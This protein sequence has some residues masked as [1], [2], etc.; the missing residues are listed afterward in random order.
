MRQVCVSYPSRRSS[1]SSLGEPEIQHLHDAVGRDDDV[2]RLQIAMHD[3]A[4]M[5]GI[6]RLA[7]LTRDRQ[8]L[9]HRQPSAEA[10][11]SSCLANARFHASLQ[12]L[13]FYQLHHERA[14]AGAFLHR[15]HRRDVGMVQ[16]RE[17]ARLALEA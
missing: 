6:Q 5:R 2:R 12:R 1:P 11:R 13:A 17:H 14:N 9:G 8:C 15:V 7:Q 4:L 10:S 16:R 3:P